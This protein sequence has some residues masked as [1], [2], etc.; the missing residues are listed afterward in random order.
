MCPCGSGRVYPWTLSWVIV[1]RLTKVAHF[2]AIRTNYH[3]KQLVD[4]YVDNILRL[5]GAPVSIISDRGTQWVSKLW[6]SLHKAIGNHLDYSTA[7]HPQTDGQTK[8]VNQILEDMLQACMLKYGIDWE[9][10][11]PHAKF[12]YNNSYQASI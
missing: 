5:H 8:R 3:V 1:D 6:Q 12:S 10:G 2:V 11:L 4:L 7:Y 9:K